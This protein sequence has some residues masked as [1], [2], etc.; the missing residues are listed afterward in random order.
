MLLKFRLQEG[1]WGGILG[2][3]V[4][5]ILRMDSILCFILNLIPKNSGYKYP[6]YIEIFSIFNS[7]F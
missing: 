5:R 3:I 2:G 1:L 6:P 4:V 7:K